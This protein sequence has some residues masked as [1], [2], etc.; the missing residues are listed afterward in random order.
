MIDC[1]FVEDRVT[2]IG[3][4]ISRNGISKGPKADAVTKMPPPS[5]VTQLYSFLGSVQFYNKFLP[6]LSTIGSALPLTEKNIKPF[7]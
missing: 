2:Y 6:D 4:T 7:I 3:H 1:V 5:K